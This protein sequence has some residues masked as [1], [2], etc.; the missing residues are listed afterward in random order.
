MTCGDCYFYDVCYSRIADGYDDD[1]CGNVIQDVENRCRHFK[2]KSC[3][4]ELPAKFGDTVWC[5]VFLNG[6]I[7]SCEV[8]GINIHK[9]EDRYRKSYILVRLPSSGSA[10]IRLNDIGERL[11]FTEEDA[12]K[13]VAER[14]GKVD[15]I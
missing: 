7:Q 12:K 8:V 11:F 14:T 15:S 5:D 4:V 1:N 10:K 6:F 2:D 9:K 13:A 3:I